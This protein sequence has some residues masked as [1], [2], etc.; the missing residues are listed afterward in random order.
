MEDGWN[1]PQSVVPFKPSTS[2]MFEFFRAKDA[3]HHEAKPICNP[4]VS[5]TEGRSSGS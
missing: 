2:V 5:K 3:F 1:L 4:G